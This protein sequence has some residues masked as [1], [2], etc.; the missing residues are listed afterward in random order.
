AASAAA[1]PMLRH[2]RVAPLLA[3]GAGLWPRAMGPPYLADQSQVMVAEAEDPWR[4]TASLRLTMPDA[5]TVTTEA[6]AAAA[7]AVL[8]GTRQPGFC[9]PS[10]LLGPG[11]LET[12]ASI[13]LHESSAGDRQERRA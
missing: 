3:R 5:Y 12:I 4:R 1:A 10:Q 2:P 13:R 8:S 6:A 7:R 11:F 9:T